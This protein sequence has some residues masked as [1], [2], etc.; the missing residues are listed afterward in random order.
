MAAVTTTLRPSFEYGGAQGKLSYFV[1]G[2][3]DHNGIG[4]ENPTASATPI[5]DTTDQYKTFTYL[6]YILTIRAIN[7]MGSAS[8]S[9]FQVPNTPGW[10][11]EPRPRRPVE[12][13]GRPNATLTPPP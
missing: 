7:F 2:S 3:Y 6:S 9:D 1:D 13:N 5:H 12:L 8:Y 4:I 11:S 10:A